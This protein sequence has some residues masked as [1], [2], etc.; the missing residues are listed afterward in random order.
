VE[1]EVLEV[2]APSL[3]RYTWVGDEGDS[4]TFVTYQLEP[5][6]GGTRFTFD[7]SG[8]RGIGG[9]LT[10]KVLR[11]VRTRMLAKGLAEV[12]RGLDE[13]PQLEAGRS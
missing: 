7:H 3:L 5:I 8:F 11:R 1:C 6:D 10:S 9:F 13:G 2:R 12:L 4:P